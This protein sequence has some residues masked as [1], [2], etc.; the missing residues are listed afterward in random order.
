MS[1][2]PALKGARKEELYGIS[3][4]SVPG[5]TTKQFSVGL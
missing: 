2:V 3:A 1:S 4:A 5:F